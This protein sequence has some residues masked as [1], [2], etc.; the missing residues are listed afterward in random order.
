M[1][2]A[3]RAF[4]PWGGVAVAAAARSARADLVHGLHVELARVTGRRASRSVVTIFDLV[5]L[6]HPASMPSPLRRQAY[7]RVVE[8]SLRRADAVIAP[9][10]ATAERLLAHGLDEGRLAVIP[11]TAGPG[12]GPSTEVEREEA[13]RRFAGGRRYVVASTGRRGHKNLAGMAAAAAQLP[14]EITVLATGAPPP[15]T[16][17]I[18]FTGR[19]SEDDL[20]ALYGGA[21]AMVLPAFVEGFGLPALEALACG[22]PV[23]CGPGT[24]ALAYL[25][26]GALEVDVGR[27]DE[28]AEAIRAL[29][30]DDGLR[31]RLAEAGRAAAAGLTVEK[32]AQST[33]AVYARVLAAT[34]R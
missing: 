34:S 13:R 15:S 33:L 4:T 20:C 3:P 11:L 5:P 29:L 32:M 21:E 8:A 24:G 10:P 1:V 27:P 12:F 9:S 23:V 31:S 2:R 26:A 16:S 22:V 7:R 25:R 6:D 17:S 19:L 18:V 28:L 30:D 14:G